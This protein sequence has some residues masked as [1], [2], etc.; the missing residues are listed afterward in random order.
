MPDGVR[1]S[2]EHIK[3]SEPDSIEPKFLALLLLRIVTR[4]EALEEV[5]SRHE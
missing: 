3:A 5:R 1:E 2:L 4:L